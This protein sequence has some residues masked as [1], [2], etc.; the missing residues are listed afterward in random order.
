MTAAWVKIF[1]DLSGIKKSVFSAYSSTTL[2]TLKARSMGLSITDKFRQGNWS[3]TSTRQKQYD[4][5]F[6]SK[7]ANDRHK[8]H[9]LKLCTLWKNRSL[10][11]KLTQ[12][13]E[14]TWF[15]RKTIIILLEN[16]SKIQIFI[17]NCK[18]KLLF[19]I[20]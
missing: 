17:S 16:S 14:R 20:R 7:P 9:G 11:G 10:K 5:Y 8:I 15:L 13:I 2:S 19:S 1:L 12:I 18:I 3:G 6:R 4:K